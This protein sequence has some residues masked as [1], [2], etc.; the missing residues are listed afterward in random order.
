M[1]NQ[2]LNIFTA[3]KSEEI[4]DI[5]KDLTEIAIDQ[6][7]QDGLLK[8]IPI[9]STAYNIYNLSLNISNSFFTKKILK[10]LFELK[11]IPIS[12]RLNFIEKM[13]NEDKT[14]RIGEKILI[15]LN[16][17]DDVDKATIL[18]KLFKLTIEDIIETSVFMRLSHMI[19]KSYL[20]DLHLLKKIDSLENIDDDIK[21][22]LSQVG[23]LN[24][25]IKDN[26]DHEE[27]VYKNTGRREFYPPNFEYKLSDFGDIIL[28]YGI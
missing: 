21:H 4:K 19:D 26:R 13:E 24:Q 22:N 9:V 3:V 23:I 17:I 8:D 25:S 12:E 6:L 15:I 27:Y 5:T 28:K 14:K 20:E 7:L 16:K 11:S 1:E 10:F 2:S 18:G